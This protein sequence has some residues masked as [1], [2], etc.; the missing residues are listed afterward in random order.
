MT[1]TTF[2]LTLDDA[3]LAGAFDRSAAAHRQ[4]RRTGCYVAVIGSGAAGLAAADTL[5][6]AGHFITVFERAAQAGGRLRALLPPGTG[7][8]DRYLMALAGEGIVFRTGIEIGLDLPIDWLWDDYNAIVL[9]MG[10][11][12][13]P[14]LN[15]WLGALPLRRTP[16]GTVSCDDAGMTSAAGIFVVAPTGGSQ[17]LIASGVA[18]GRRVARAVDAYLAGT[19]RVNRNDGLTASNM[20]MSSPTARGRWEDRG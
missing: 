14:A 11:A 6:Q 4:Q 3:D 19:S 1:V 15:R 9:A 2:P 16:A 5:N 18:A 10:G 20:V 12:D 13:D 8:L 17:P 7:A